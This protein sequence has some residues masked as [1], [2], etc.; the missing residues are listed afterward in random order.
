MMGEE[1]LKQMLVDSVKE[2]NMEESE[3][4]ARKAL[5][6]GID[7]LEALDGVTGA[8]KEIDDAFA[9]GD[10]FLV[11]MM[12]SAEAAKRAMVVIAPKIK[13][14][15]KGITYRGKVLIGTVEGDIHDIGKSIVAVFLDIEG[16][17]VIDLG[18]DVPTGT[19]VEKVRE[20][21]PDVLGLSA[22][23]TSTMP[24]QGDVIQALE[25]E[26]LRGGVKVIV[27][28]S[29]VTAIWAEEIGADSY[30]ADAIEAVEKVKELTN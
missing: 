19:F 3:E 29:P 21:K 13:E 20:L 12:R 11:H 15:N 5:G 26:G 4:I 25:R 27:G 7:P 16:F 24:I 6:T 30:G 18:I 28:G 8:L 14:Q 10:M 2:G 1:F 22:L 23:V 17:D 9:N